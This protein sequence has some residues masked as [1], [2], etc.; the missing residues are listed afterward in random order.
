V[1]LSVDGFL[2]TTRISGKLVDIVTAAS[3][4]SSQFGVSATQVVNDLNSLEST[5]TQGKSVLNQTLQSL[6]DANNF[7][8]IQLTTVR[9][10]AINTCAL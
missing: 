7:V 8:G 3:S 10:L 1:G 5:L 2:L 9:M 6:L 4:I